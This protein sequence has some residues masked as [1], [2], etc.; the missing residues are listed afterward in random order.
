MQKDSFDV[1][2]PACNMLVEAKVI[3][4]GSGGLRSDAVNPIDEVDAEYHGEHYSVA[5]CRRCCGPF[6]VRESLFGVPGEFETITKEELLFPIA[7]ARSLEGVPEPVRR[8]IEQADRSFVTGS[9]D[10]AALMCRRALE[11]VCR[12]L[13]A[14]GSNLALKLRDLHEKGHIDQKLLSW[15]HGVRLVGNEA[16][17][18]VEDAVT[19]EDARDILDLTGAILMY[20]FSLDRK[21]REFESRRTGRT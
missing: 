14:S 19:K 9:Y 21:F 3:A 4:N 1:F 5:L 15:A 2:C 10:A 8:S 6:L 12:A 13:S 17:H 11:A 18:D 20:I 16:A 7:T